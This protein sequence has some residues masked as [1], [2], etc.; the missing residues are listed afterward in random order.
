MTFYNYAIMKLISCFSLQMQIL[1]LL[2]LQT[3]RE[4][5]K[6]RTS[7]SPTFSKVHSQSTIYVDRQEGKLV[8]QRR[9]KDADS[10]IFTNVIL[11]FSG[12]RYCYTTQSTFDMATFSSQRNND[13]SDS[14]S[15]SLNCLNSM[16]AFT[17][18]EF[19]ERVLIKV[20]SSQK[21]KQRCYLT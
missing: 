1:Q 17:C 10:V 12:Y 18:E 21:Q 8:N 4:G 14:P 7:P 13:S 11:S 19:K 15:K 6:F 2:N 5:Y 3:L 20:R 16:R 9:D